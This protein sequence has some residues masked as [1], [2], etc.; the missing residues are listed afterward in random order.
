MGQH[1]VPQRAGR[2]ILRFYVKELEMW[3]R[4]R[5]DCKGLPSFCPGEGRLLRLFFLDRVEGVGGLAKDRSCQPGAK[6][7]GEGNK[8]PL[9]YPA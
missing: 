9:Q 3:R 5:Q 1:D 4:L 6:I 7:P 2:Q 8:K